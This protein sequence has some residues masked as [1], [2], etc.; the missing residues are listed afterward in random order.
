MGWTIR[1]W[2]LA[3]LLP[4][5]AFGVVVPAAIALRKA[6][7]SAGDDEI[8]GE[9]EVV[10][11]WASGA[12]TPAE[13]RPAHSGRAV[14]FVASSPAD[15][16]LLRT[17]F[18]EDGDVGQVVVSVAAWPDDPWAY[19][20]RAAWLGEASFWPVGPLQSEAR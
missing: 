5:L 4:V 18:P 14:I 10:A 11:V 9:A 2:T 3:A 16:E 8:E 20:A 15:A 6:A 13:A 17:V 1:E 19:L 7:G 12:P